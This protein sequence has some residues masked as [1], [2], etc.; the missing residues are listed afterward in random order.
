MNCIKKLL[1][2]LA[3]VLGLASITDSAFAYTI[4]ANQSAN[5][6]S[7]G[8]YY[9]FDAVSG[10]KAGTRY[11]VL[12]NTSGTMHTGNISG[13]NLIDSV[14]FNVALSAAS[15]GEYIGGVLST[16]T[17]SLTGSYNLSVSNVSLNTGANIA[18]AI[19]GT[20]TDSG[21]LSFTGTIDGQ[22][23]Q[24]AS[25]GINL[26]Y[27]NFTTGAFGGVYDSTVAAFGGGTV[28]FGLDIVGNDNITHGWTS[29][30]G[31]ITFNGVASGFTYF[32]DLHAPI[33]GV[34]S[35]PEPTSVAL[36]LSG[37]IGAGLRRKRTA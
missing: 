19:N 32:G 6:G 28:N 33:T 37:V 22:T 15:V 3:L 35:V 24:L 20:A 2:S 30:S 8:L 4:G 29:G 26:N 1:A 14:T 11:V 17:A 36:F 10:P 5:L 16:K 27:M 34:S 12:F 31:S 7:P 23:V 9:T 21:T 18:A 25:S 13:G